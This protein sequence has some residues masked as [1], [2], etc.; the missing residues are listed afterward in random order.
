V[1]LPVL[2]TEWKLETRAV[3]APL[4]A[5]VQEV[6]A[7]LA[8]HALVASLPSGKVVSLGFVAPDTGTL[9]DAEPA[10]CV[11][12]GE[13]AARQCEAW[14]EGFEVV[15]GPFDLDGDASPEWVVQ[16]TVARASAAHTRVQSLVSV[17]PAPAKSKA[18]REQE[19]F[20]RLR[21]ARPS[22]GVWAPLGA[23]AIVTDIS[24]QQRF[25]TTFD[26]AKLVEKRVAHPALVAARAAKAIPPADDCNPTDPRRDPGLFQCFRHDLGGSPELE[27]VLVRF[28]EQSA[29]AQSELTISEGS[30][31]LY[32]ALVDRPRLEAPGAIA[33]L[34]TRTAGYHDVL[35]RDPEGG[36]DRV[37]QFADTT[38]AEPS[39]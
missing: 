16:A 17:R 8:R 31:V 12:R 2:A 37:I 10:S 26:G 7:G 27:Y 13:G 39:W 38:Y 19:R 28:V 14:V 36:D 1:A 23:P 4:D 29:T 24:G 22:T 30:R 34:P 15:A 5:R 33:I 3:P 32:R 21:M 35:L 18:P 6:P 11:V 25:V 9:V 20:L